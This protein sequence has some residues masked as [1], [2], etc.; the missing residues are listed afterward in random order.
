MT[1][2]N[3][4]FDNGLLVPPGYINPV[5]PGYFPWPITS[6]AGTNIIDPTNAAVI[7]VATNGNDAISNVGGPTNPFLT[8]AAAINYRSTIDPTTPVT[9]MVG[10]GAFGG[11][12]ALIDNT[13]VVG[14]A[15]TNTG[16]NFANANYPTVI[17]APITL[18]N[19]LIGGSICGISNLALT[20]VTVSSTLV[21]C[22]A[23]I[24]DCSVSALSS[25][26]AL[27][28]NQVASE[29]V[30]LNCRNCRFFSDDPINAAPLVLAAGVN[31]NNLTFN[32]CRFNVL[33]PMSRVFLV[34]GNL[35]IE[36]CD[37][38]NT[39]SDDT[40]EPLIS[41]V[42]DVGAVNLTVNGS[43]LSYSDVTNVEVSGNKLAVL[44]EPAI[45]YA[46]TAS[47]TNNTINIFLGGGNHDIIK[48]T[49]GAGTDVN[50]TQGANICTL[51]G[52]SIDET[53][54]TSLPAVFLNNVPA[55]N[56]QGLYQATYYKSA[57]Q[58]LT[59]GATDLTFDQ[60]GSWNNDGGYI[61]HTGGSADFT[62][63][64]AGL[65]QLEFNATVIANGSTNP[66]S[67]QKL[68]SVDITRSPSA[69]VVAIQQN[70]TIASGLTYGQSLC[71]TFNLEAGDV[72]NCRVLNTFTGGPAQA[73]GASGTIDL[74]TWFTWRYVNCGAAGPTGPQGPTGAT[75]PAGATGATGAS[76]PPAA[77][78]PLL[79]ATYYMSANQNLT[80]GTTDLTFDEVGSWNNDSGYIT[81]T[82]GS[83]N[84]TVVEGGLYQLEF[85]ATIISNGATWTSL[86]K[87][88]SV[89]VTRTSPTEIVAI[90][91]NASMP[92]NT[93]YAQ[94]LCSTLY[95][96][97]GDVINCRVTNTYASGTPYAQCLT[98]TID[99]NTW[100][101]WRYVN[102]GPVGPTGP[103]GASGATGPTGASG[104]NG[105]T[106]P[107]GATGASGAT[108]PT[109]ASGA[110]GPEGPTGA[111]GASGSIGASGP[112]GASGPTGASGP[113]GASGATGDTGPTG[114]TG[115]AGVG[116]TGATGPA[117]AINIVSDSVSGP[118]GLSTSP[119]QLL[120][121][122]SFTPTITGFAVAT[123]S[124][125][126]RANTNNAT[127]VILNIRDNAG[128]V[129]QIMTTSM[130]S[131]NQL[132]PISNTVAI[133]TVAGV[134]N[135][136]YVDLTLNA[137]HSTDFM[138]GNLVVTYT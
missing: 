75:G 35:V 52:Y 81:H 71:S 18:T 34:V 66:S 80:S 53:N 3:I 127:D 95:L 74:N 138:G 86:S 110:S 67:T 14:A 89:D 94:N 134:A 96:L 54:I 39:G 83:T 45:G 136:V 64:Q 32:S 103:A 65:Y 70:T 22:N 131:T 119:A 122:T 100:F 33:S 40:F 38:S 4:P 112:A 60:V 15:A 21:P 7:Y 8:I 79:Q 92:S 23:N 118:T 76:G 47:V 88:I 135:T 133:P 44:F 20:G 1:E 107:A 114:A 63:V 25:E 69:E 6:G 126:V 50:L 17:T 26:S 99:L 27:Y 104:A 102:T 46:C 123:A 90:A 97:T 82:G 10:P 31:A 121:T 137:A 2:V 12:W 48:S 77:V 78:Q 106:G 5:T 132:S 125:T 43:T 120:N 101:T 84:F 128:S 93:N 29:L 115:P 124:V 113:A 42:G 130:T 49:G 61:T 24:T 109:G 68:L 19:S 59:S 13:W 51:D 108:G 55:G 37:I 87:Q 98:N 105:V 16:S 91:Q 11:A 28:A 36:D 111:S 62:V 58:N 56:G 85:N 73:V 116:A 41:L 30:T 9:I 117:G 72:I 57:N 129:G